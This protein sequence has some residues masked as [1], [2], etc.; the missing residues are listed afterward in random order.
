MQDISSWIDWK[1]SAHFESL[2]FH[3]RG[4]PLK[5]WL[6]RGRLLNPYL[7]GVLIHLLRREMRPKDL[8]LPSE[9]CSGRSYGLP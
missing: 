7:R 9:E 8:I 1:R 5:L 2:K 6:G 3:R 4:L